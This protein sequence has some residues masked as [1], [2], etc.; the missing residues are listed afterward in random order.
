M[1]LNKPMELSDMVIALEVAE[2]QIQTAEVLVHAGRLGL[3]SSPLDRARNLIWEVRHTLERL[4]PAAELD[5]EEV[6]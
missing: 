6:E 1:D 4:C 2:E 3:L 5:A